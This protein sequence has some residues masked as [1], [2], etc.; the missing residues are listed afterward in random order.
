M[1]ERIAEILI[2]RGAEMATPPTSDENFG[3]RFELDGEVVEVLGPDG[4]RR[5]PKTVGRYSTFK[6]AGGTQAL[7]R[8]EAV[9]VSLEGESAVDVRR[10][11]LLGAILI[12]ARVAAKERREKFQSDRLDLVRLLTFVEDP[13]ALAEKEELRKSEVRWLRKV[14]HLLDFADPGLADVLTTDTVARAEQA[15]RLL[16]N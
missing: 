16:T 4:V 8:S 7:R 5:E 2:E 9:R 10:P 12:K 6:V 1:T 13:R 3:Y 14:E 15:F 11:R